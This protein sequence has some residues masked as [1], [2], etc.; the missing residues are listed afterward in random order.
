MRGLR[1]SRLQEGGIR[2]LRQA[3][4]IWVVRDEE[5]SYFSDIRTLIQIL[6]RYSSVSRNF[7]ADRTTWVL[8]I[9]C[10]GYVMLA[11]CT[12][13][14]SHFTFVSKNGIFY[15]FFFIILNH[16]SYLFPFRSTWSTSK[17]RSRMSKNLF[18]KK[19]RI[20]GRTSIRTIFGIWSISTY[21]LRKMDLKIMR[22]WMVNAHF[23]NN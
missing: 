21:R 9:V 2:D 17:S 23:L 19:S 4:E 22:A 20:T 16:I 6:K 1:G 13:W 12:K 11:S 3:H 18:T 5:S 15:N 8:W 10:H 14:W 7:S